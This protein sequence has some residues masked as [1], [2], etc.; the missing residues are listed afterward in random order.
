MFNTGSGKS[1]CYDN[2]QSTLKEKLC[3]CDGKSFYELEAVIISHASKQHYGGLE[4]LLN[5]ESKIA[6]KQILFPKTIENEREF[7]TLI[8]RKFEPAR[9]FLE[10]ELQTIFESD[11][12]FVFHPNAPGILYKPIGKVGSSEKP[13]QMKSY[14]DHP[15]SNAKGILLLVKV[16]H[17]DQ[18]CCSVFGA[19]LPGDYVLKHISREEKLCILQVPQQ[20]KTEGSTSYEECSLPFKEEKLQLAEEL[21]SAATLLTLVCFLE[22]K[23]GLSKLLEPLLYFMSLHGF[24]TNVTNDEIVAI[25]EASSSCPEIRDDSAIIKYAKYIIDITLTMITKTRKREQTGVSKVEKLKIQFHRDLPLYNDQLKMLKNYEERFPLLS[26]LKSIIYEWLTFV[27]EAIMKAEFYTQL[28][29]Q[30]Y[31]VHTRT[32]DFTVIAGIQVAAA[33]NEHHCQILFTHSHRLEKCMAVVADMAV[34][35]A[36]AARNKKKGKYLFTA[37]NEKEGELLSKFAS[38][39]S[40]VEENAFSTIDF[41]GNIKSSFTRLNHV[42]DILRNIDSPSPALANKSLKDFQEKTGL[43]RDVNLS[44]VLQHVIGPD[45]VSQMLDEQAESLEYEF[46]EYGLQIKEI[47]KWKVHEEHTKFHMNETFTAVKFAVVNLIVPRGQYREI[48]SAEL[49]IENA[50]DVALSLKLN[51]ITTKQKT[52]IELSRSLKGLRSKGVTLAEHLVSVVCSMWE[53]AMKLKVVEAV[54]PLFGPSFVIQVLHVLPPSLSSSITQIECIFDH[55]MSSVTRDSS[56]KPIGL[57]FT[58]PSFTL[59]T[60]SGISLSIKRLS[61]D[62]SANGIHSNMKLTGDMAIEDPVSEVALSA[63][64]SFSLGSFPEVILKL[65]SVPPDLPSLL[66]LLKLQGIS[67]VGDS[68]LPIIGKKLNDIVL[69]SVSLTMQKNIVGFSSILIETGIQ[70]E[71]LN[72]PFPIHWTKNCD[73]HVLILKPFSK[74]IAVGIRAFFF[75]EVP[76]NSCSASLDASFEIKISRSQM[77]VKGSVL[78]LKPSFRNNSQTPEMKGEDILELLKAAVKD[79]KEIGSQFIEKLCKLSIFSTECMKAVSLKTFQ[80]KQNDEGIPS[81]FHLELLFTEISIM[82]TIKVKNGILEFQYTPKVLHLSCKG[83][84]VIFGTCEIYLQFTLPTSHSEGV[85]VIDNPDKTLILSRFV[86]ALGWSSTLDNLPFVDKCLD[87]ALNKLHLRLRLNGTTTYISRAEVTLQISQ[88]TF[89]SDVSPLSLSQLIVSCIFE[90]N[91]VG[92]HNVQLSISGTIG[93]HKLSLKYD[94]ESKELQGEGCVDPQGVLNAMR[95]FE[96]KEYNFHLKQIEKMKTLKEKMKTLNEESGYREILESRTV[97]HLNIV[98]GIEKIE[99]S[100]IADLKYIGSNISHIWSAETMSFQIKDFQAEY[101]KIADGNELSHTGRL[102]GVMQARE[103]GESTTLELDIEKTKSKS[104]ITAQVYP[105]PDGKT[106]TLRSIFNT[107]IKC[108]VPELPNIPGI[109]SFFDISLDSGTLFM[110]PK[111]NITSFSLTIEAP[112]WE[113]IKDPNITLQRLHFTANWSEG[114]Q[115]KCC[116]STEIHIGEYVIKLEGEIDRSGVVLKLKTLKCS[117]TTNPTLLINYDTILKELPPPDGA[118]LTA[119]RVPQNVELPSDILELKEFTIELKEEKTHICF[120]WCLEPEWRIGFG[121]SVFT[122]IHAGGRLE[123]DKKKSLSASYKA[124]IY[125]SLN[126]GKLN[127]RLALHL[128]TKFSSTLKGEIQPSDDA[129]FSK[130][131]NYLMG[132]QGSLSSVMSNLTP[133]K[134]DA[135]TS[136]SKAL[137]LFNIPKRNFLFIGKLQDW[138]SATLVV[139]KFKMNKNI[140]FAF[141]FEMQNFQFEW[142]ADD[143]KYL[144]HLIHLRYVK[145][146]ISTVENQTFSQISKSFNVDIP[147]EYQTPKYT[148]AGLAHATNTCVEEKVLKKGLV[149]IADLDLQLC[150]KSKNVIGHMYDIAEAGELGVMNL[151]VII[152]ATKEVSSTKPYILFTLETYM[153]ELKV[154]GGL[155]LENIEVRYE[156]PRS[157]ESHLHLSADVCFE[158]HE[159]GSLRFVGTFDIDKDRA[160]FA[161]KK[162]SDDKINDSNVIEIPVSLQRL[163]L[164]VEYNFKSREIPFVEVVG[165]IS[166]L[167]GAIEIGAIVLF[168]KTEFKLFMIKIT[169]TFSMSKL[170]KAIGFEW[171]FGSKDERSEFIDI[172]NG[173]VHYA[174]KDIVYQDELYES[175]CHLKVKMTLHIFQYK[176]NIWVGGHLDFKNMPPTLTIWGQR[177][178]KVTLGDWIEVSDDKFTRGPILE[179]EICCMKPKLSLIVGVSFGK[180]KKKRFVGKISFDISLLALTGEICYCGSIGF[181]KNPT[182]GIT[183]SILTADLSVEL[184][185]VGKIPLTPTAILKTISKWI[186]TAAREIIWWDFLIKLKLKKNPDPNKYLLQLVIQGSLKIYFRIKVVRDKCYTYTLPLPDIPINIPNFKELRFEEIPNM[187]LETIMTISEKIACWLYGKVKNVLPNIF[188]NVCK[189]VAVA[190]KKISNL[191]NKCCNF[192]KA[193]RGNSYWI[194]DESGQILAY[195]FGEREGK[196]LFT[197]PSNEERLCI[198]IGPLISLVAIQMILSDVITNTESFKESGNIEYKL[199]KEDES[200]IEEL[201]QAKPALEKNLEGLKRELFKVEEI[202]AEL[203]EEAEVTERIVVTWKMENKELDDD[204]GDMEH[205]VHILATAV[206]YDDG[207]KIS[208]ELYKEVFQGSEKKTTLKC[209][210]IE[211][212]NPLFVIIGIQSGIT[213]LVK[214]LPDRENE[215]SDRD[216]QRKNIEERGREKEVMISGDFH[217]RQK[218]FANTVPFSLRIANTFYDCSN[219]CIECKVD[220]MSELQFQCYLMQVVDESNA[221]IVVCQ[222]VFQPNEPQHLNLPQLFELPN[223][224]HG[225]Y[226]VRALGIV[227]LT[228]RTTTETFSFSEEKIHRLLSPTDVKQTF[229]DTTTEN[230]ISLQSQGRSISSV[231][232]QWNSPDINHQ[233]KYKYHWKLISK[234]D[235]FQPESVNKTDKSQSERVLLSDDIENLYE[236]KVK[237]PFKDILKHHFE[238]SSLQFKVYTTVEV[239]KDQTVSKLESVPA[240]APV[241]YILLPPQSLNCKFEDWFV[242]EWDHASYVS[243][244]TIVLRDTCNVNAS[245][246]YEKV[247]ALESLSCDDKQLKLTHK[248]IFRSDHDIWTSNTG[249]RPKYSLEIFS[250]GDMSEYL[251]S[252]LP[253]RCDRLLQPIDIQLKYDQENDCLKVLIP[254]NINMR[255]KFK[256]CIIVKQHDKEEKKSKDSG[257]GLDKC[258]ADRGFILSNDKWTDCIFKEETWRESVFPGESIAVWVSGSISENEITILACGMSNSL[259]VIS[260]VTQPKSAIHSLKQGSIDVISMACDFKGEKTM[261]HYGLKD[262]K[263][264]ILFCD[265]TDRLN[266]SIRMC[267]VMFDM[268][269]LSYSEFQCYVQVPTSSEEFVGAYNKEPHTYQCIVVPNSLGM[270]QVIYNSVLLT[271]VLCYKQCSTALKVFHTLGEIEVFKIPELHVHHIHSHNKTIFPDFHQDLKRWFLIGATEG[272][273]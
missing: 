45:L 253:T 148:C 85:M 62:L 188:E 179:L 90:I 125:G 69:K 12:N 77:K 227:N 44:T 66:R 149:F 38:F 158:S 140:Q 159:F 250:E 201:K 24:Q 255:K 108:P 100:F 214:A 180:N 93:G 174:K 203:I 121:S 126:I 151:S 135:M 211:I 177:E 226:H 257:V 83:T 238:G 141:M 195:I 132:T 155:N 9:A 20:G 92:E 98:F 186:A 215:E 75:V 79:C 165:E 21:Q 57:L 230:E 122:V 204:E 110:T 224:S 64:C 134:V 252:T 18:M 236:V 11:F 37:S 131:G 254:S 82:Q 91:E 81:G 265:R 99:N 28:K 183:W 209:C 104:D 213:M 39:L 212:K 262:V 232:I 32:C 128:G 84:I 123:V 256:V 235:K 272:N 114:C 27:L 94:P 164:R 139:G 160:S 26:K 19:D 249:A 133:K 247:P 40:F 222:D 54:T 118:E 16:K 196:K 59:I 173:V 97:C 166:A 48:K 189:T 109:P 30:N 4:Q 251:K 74:N 171:P 15:S 207:F 78:S 107:I 228:D 58:I 182:L 241:F 187:I 218:G 23:K 112:P 47:L 117:N 111:F 242:A 261:Y 22:S 220:R 184:P 103:S 156:A 172:Q 240:E 258:V 146:L 192:F 176:F 55:T 205:S 130:I 3:K 17:Q 263:G 193:I 8:E 191:L 243:S 181:L 225:P 197:S 127:V 56:L 269:S 206:V 2:L 208:S 63:Q 120:D 170:L 259:T 31:L 162:P 270:H 210:E 101:T 88:Y 264:K 52:T 71:S 67:A 237:V 267:S 144:D 157:K 13:P 73:V 96:K 200:S 229:N 175:G 143:L 41:T 163:E 89:E 49:H 202:V 1:I 260:S 153:K 271:H 25:A 124:Q 102:I 87:A 198:I 154:I 246:I 33:W 68:Y 34:V 35:G 231:M 129:S 234:T 219:R 268:E 105:G 51:L 145:A 7:M 42:T 169:K 199:K 76:I 136:S 137:A 168:Q 6:I 147:P 14:L 29:A 70:V 86:S 190:G 50:R 167:R 194:E 116:L 5:G 223:H 233:T 36:M 46:Q 138:G 245:P 217:Y 72:L 239:F 161:V 152:T 216:T 244:Y 106:F 115:P 65:K 80:I 266:I 178:E 113:L 10:H 150:R 119:C 60:I 273:N 248:Y 95:V 221:T 185:V 43:Q 61:L 142:L 53:N